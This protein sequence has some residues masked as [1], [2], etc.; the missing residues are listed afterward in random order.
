MSGVNTAGR[1]NLENLK[2]WTCY[3]TD[4]SSHETWH[5]KLWN[6]S[7]SGDNIKA[8]HPNE[9]LAIPG[10]FQSLLSLLYL[11]L[12]LN[13][14][15][16]LQYNN[17]RFFTSAWDGEDIKSIKCENQSRVL[18]CS[19]SSR[20]CILGSSWKS[21]P[22]RN[23]MKRIRP[24]CFNVKKVQNVVRKTMESKKMRTVAKKVDKKTS[25]VYR[26]RVKVKSRKVSEIE[27]D[28]NQKLNK[29][30]RRNI[31]K[32]DSRAPSY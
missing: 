32:S 20:W 10:Y 9:Q 23:V 6:Y 27:L 18:P 17:Y 15:F 1:F 4:D 19:Y 22:R 11:K 7:R 3:A 24:S 14:T 31:K 2:Y 8:E 13:P 5:H 28:R 21:F 16:H 26:T 30:W 12:H 29:D 25:N